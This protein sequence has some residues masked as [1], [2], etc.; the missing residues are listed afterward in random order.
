M[1]VTLYDMIIQRLNET[2][3]PSVLKLIDQTD[4][5]H[6]H[7]HFQAGKSHFKLHISS[8]KFAKLSAI[9]AHQE[10]YACLSDLMH[11]KIHALSIQIEKSEFKK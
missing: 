9:T 3:S 10:I 5:H 8:E 7:K 2:F 1:T 11:S 6:K 4:Q